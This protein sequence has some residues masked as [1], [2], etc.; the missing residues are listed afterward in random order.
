MMYHLRISIDGAIR[1]KMFKGFIE[2]GKELSPEIAES[3]LKLLRHEGKKYLKIGE[4]DNWSEEEGCLGH[5]DTVQ[6]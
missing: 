5:E 6:V 4:C 1:N 3:K 2:N